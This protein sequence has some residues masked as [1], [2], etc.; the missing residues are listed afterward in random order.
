MS[1]FEEKVFANI[2]VPIINLELAKFNLTKEY[3]KQGYDIYDKKDNFIM[4]NLRL[5]IILMMI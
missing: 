4:I 3:A 2:Y 5:Q 1:C